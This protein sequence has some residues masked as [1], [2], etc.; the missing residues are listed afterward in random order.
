MQ[1]LIKPFIHAILSLLVI[2][3]LTTASV[4]LLAD[5]K[6]ETGTATGTKLQVLSSPTCGCC[7]KWVEHMQAN[8]FDASVEH[9]ADLNQE[10]T[11]RGIAPQYQSCHTA[12]SADGYVF[13]GHIPARVIQ[14]FLKEKHQ[15]AIGLAAPGMPMGSPGMEMGDHF[16]PYDVLVLKAD[17]SSSVYTRIGAAAEQ[18]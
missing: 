6:A 1:Q 3:T 14:R 18:Y 15:D 16:S 17:G 13:E 2:G 7:G 4:T 5:V 11:A 10:K 12:V 9:P 8:G